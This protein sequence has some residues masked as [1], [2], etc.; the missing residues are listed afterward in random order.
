MEWEP[1]TAPGSSESLYFGP[2]AGYDTEELDRGGLDQDMNTV[3]DF[4][5]LPEKESTVPSE[6]NIEQKI[7]PGPPIKAWYDPPPTPEQGQKQGQ[8]LDQ[9]AFPTWDEF[10]QTTTVHGVRYIFDKSTNKLRR[11][12]LTFIVQTCVQILKAKHL[13]QIMAFSTH[14]TKCSHSQPFQNFSQ[15]L[16]LFKVKLNLWSLFRVRLEISWGFFFVCL[17]KTSLAM[18][19]FYF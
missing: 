12:E 7:P 5:W 1:I 10:T 16:I 6:E 17:K 14:T 2:L 19:T 11:S 8:R 3:Q 4:K 9:D 18:V 15:I 13:M